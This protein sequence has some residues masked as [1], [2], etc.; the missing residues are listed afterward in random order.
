V[1]VNDCKVGLW[2]KSRL[3]AKTIVWRNR[4]AALE[5]KYFPEYENKLLASKMLDG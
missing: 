2:E 1:Y 5:G 3:T 4:G